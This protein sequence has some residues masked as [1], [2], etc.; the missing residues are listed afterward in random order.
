MSRRLPLFLR[1]SPLLAVAACG[2]YAPAN[3]TDTTKP[4]YQSDLAECQAFGD[5][6]GYRLVMSK[7]PLFLIYPISLPIMERRQTAKC[8]DGKGYAAE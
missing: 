1:I 8:M 7:G 2:G 6:E 5:K 3:P 4:S